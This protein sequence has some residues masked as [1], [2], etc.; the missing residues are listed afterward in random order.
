M[1]TAAEQKRNA[2]AFVERWKAA[3]GNEDREAR[4]FW[5]E[6]TQ[7]LYGIADATKVLEF[8]RRVRGRKMD[9]LYE[10]MGI[11][12]EQKGRGVSL[13]D[14]RHTSKYGDETP[15]DQARWYYDQMPRSV[16]PH[17]IITCNFDEFRIYDMDSEYPERGFVTVTLDELADNLYLFDFFTDKNKSRVEKEKHVSVKAGELVGELY[18][19]LAKQYRDIEHD[20][21]EQRS[22]NV[23]CVRL[24]FL[25]YA[26]DAGLLRTRRQFYDYLKPIPANLMRDA[27]VNL[28][29]VL[30]TPEDRRDPYLEEHLAA[31]PYI[32]GGLFAKHDVAVPQFNDQI[33]YTLLQKAAAGFD[34]KGISPTIFGAVFESTLNPETRRTG[35]MHYTSIE[36][37]HRLIDP[38]FLDDL[39][40]E[41]AAIEGMSV[42]RERKFELLR[43]Q[44]KLSRINLFDPACGSGNFLTESYISLR[45]L[46]NR[47]LETLQG[48]EQLRLDVDGAA[49]YTIKVNIGQLHGVEIADFAVSVAKTALWIAEAQMMEVT[50]EILW[51]RFDFLPLKSI[52]HIHDGNALRMDWNDVL[53]ADK[54]S[55]LLGNP[56]FLGYTMQTPSQKA[57][58]EVVFGNTNVS[59]KIDYVA[60]WYKKAADYVLDEET[61]CAFVST[62]SICQGEQ[63]P[64]LW[65]Y[66]LDAGVTIDFAWPTFVWNSEAS[67]QAHVHVVIVGFHK[68]PKDRN[69]LILT[70]GKRAEAQNINPY[71]SDAPTV[72]VSSRSKPICPVP[73]ISKG[74]QPTDG[75]NLIIGAKEELDAITSAEPELGKY[76]RRFVGSDEFINDR[77]RWCF[78]LD[79]APEALLNTSAILRERL[80]AVREMRLASTKASTREAAATPALFTEIRQPSSSYIMIP[81]VSSERREYV[82][83]GFLGKND[84]AS[85]LAM[86]IQNATLYHFGVLS[87]QFHNAWMRTVAGRLES[88][89]RYSNKI[90]YNNFVWPSPTPGQKAQIERCAQLVLD[91]RKQYPDKSLAQ[92]YDPDLM[93]E[94][95]L[96]AHKALDMA[97]EDAYGVNFNGD[98]EKIVAHLFKLYAAKTGA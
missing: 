15:Y 59:K 36:C 46:E 95:L 35:G 12:V 49:G 8:E 77:Y 34:W 47:V 28:F 5:I 91:V 42:L 45:K 19:E 56:P 68:G 26:E 22:L 87:S 85:N 62:N 92:L 60:C 51:K 75:G 38:L 54:C 78:W 76:I 81:S 88:R 10:D 39:K 67:D 66:L 2:K 55:Y 16:K 11:L 57:D 30:D 63:V 69:Q 90:V 25:L 82:P 72:L 84:I 98:E 89:Y 53:P 27:L 48:D 4:S 86:T 74:S 40:A 31:F 32:N 70:D 37:I 43:F 52:S 14:V 21:H 33:K 18:A 44:E 71:L 13:D 20:E 94:S 97:V 83:M 58:V 79:E 9:V 61:R 6:F 96:A 50:Q 23:L 73:P 65:G 80:N 41:L 7:E 29:V 24:V 93:P 1:L 17:W 3:E 64:D